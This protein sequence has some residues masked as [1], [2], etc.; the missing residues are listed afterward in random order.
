MRTSPAAYRSRAPSSRTVFAYA[1]G[2]MRDGARACTMVAVKHIRG[3]D[4]SRLA[5]VSSSI[6]VVAVLAAAVGSRHPALQIGLA[7]GAAVFASVVAVRPQARWWWIAD[8]VAAVC[9]VQ[10]IGN[11]SASV[12]LV[13]LYLLPM[14]AAY[15]VSRWRSVAVL[16]PCTIALAA[17]AISDAVNGISTGWYLSAAATVGTWSIG[18]V[19]QR[20]A[21][22]MAALTQAQSELSRRAAAEERQRIARDVHDMVGHSLSV[23]LLHVTGARLALDRDVSM[24]RQALLEA[25]RLGRESM[26]EIRRTVG[27]LAERGDDPG[28]APVPSAPDIAV[29]V[30]QFVRSGL[31][32]SYQPS[33]DLAALESAV[34]LVAYRIVQES[35]SNVAKH[36]PG[37]RT[38]ALAQK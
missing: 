12:A 27:L 20:Q 29:L 32:V 18:R 5:A 13:V 8:V 26:A 37:A 33:G 10:L 6:V 15:L 38:L 31:D 34:G 11:D 1:R 22:T 14:R 36:A 7:A 17:H 3:A 23:T 2:Q 25:E 21:L 4:P 35:L 16:A 9:T 24:A 30:E 28:A 19:A